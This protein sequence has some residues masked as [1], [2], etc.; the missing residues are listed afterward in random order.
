L[1]DSRR[2]A[3]V[4]VSRPEA[5]GRPPSH[6]LGARRP[7]RSPCH[8]PPRYERDVVGL[9]PPG[10]CR[11]RRAGPRPRAAQAVGAAGDGDGAGAERCFSPAFEIAYL[12][13]PEALSFAPFLISFLVWSDSRMRPSALAPL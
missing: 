9:A 8:E 3:V 11:P 10:R 13:T 2:A 1:T 12:K 4:R 5:A 6:T 7:G